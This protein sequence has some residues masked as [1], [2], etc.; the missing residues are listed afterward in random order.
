M[1]WT[2]SRAIRTA[3]RECDLTQ[4]Q[5]ARRLGVK[6]RALSRWEL[7]HCKPSKRHRAELLTAF[8][9]VD[10]EW[11]SWLANMMGSL[12]QVGGATQATS[13]AHPSAPEVDSRAVVE[14]AVFTLADELDLPARRV[15]GPLA[16]LLV[17]LR[18]ASLTLDG[19]SRALDELSATAVA[20]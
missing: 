12:A 2:I 1:R 17:R 19:A 5:L 3:R 7:G 6:G 9:H 18:Q 13:E 20:D 16:K 11:A 14:L 4:D 8:Q 10:P 15:R